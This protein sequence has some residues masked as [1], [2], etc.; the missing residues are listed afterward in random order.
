MK[1]LLVAVGISFLI[2]SCS[3][4]QSRFT[5]QQED[6]P[7]TED[8]LAARLGPVN[9]QRDMQACS[10]YQRQMHGGEHVEEGRFSECM[11]LKGWYQVVQ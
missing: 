7:G 3:T 9:L 4:T 10:K 11:V 1:Q 2:A 5:W 6:P 8:L